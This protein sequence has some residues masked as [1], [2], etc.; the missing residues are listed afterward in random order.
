MDLLGKFLKRVVYASLVYH[1]TVMSKIYA[2][3]I[4]LVSET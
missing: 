3:F 4:G 1:N 2:L